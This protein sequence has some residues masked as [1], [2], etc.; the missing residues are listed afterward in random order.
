[1]MM[2][3]IEGNISGTVEILGISDRFNIFIHLYSFSMLLRMKV[4]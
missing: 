4:L 3:M 1:M 2:M